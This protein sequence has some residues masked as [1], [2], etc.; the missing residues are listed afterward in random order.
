[1]TTDTIS[2]PGWVDIVR[3]IL[4]SPRQSASYRCVVSDLFDSGLPKAWAPRVIAEAV[5]TGVIVWDGLEHLR[6]ADASRQSQDAVR[7]EWMEDLRRRVLAAADDLLARVGKRLEAGARE[8][9]DASFQRPL[10]EVLNEI[11]D[12][13]AD[14][15]GWGFVAYVID[16]ERQLHERQTSESAT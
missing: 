4:P 13:R 8:Y 7:H 10:H 12:E 11:L 5:Q 9:G 6:G 2:L 16:R 3:K 14:I 1:V 15:L